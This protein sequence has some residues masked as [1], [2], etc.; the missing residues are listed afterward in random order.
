VV[1]KRSY[2]LSQVRPFVFQLVMQS[3][4]VPTPG[5]VPQFVQAPMVLWQLAFIPP[6]NKA[7][8]LAQLRAI[9]GA[10]QDEELV[11]QVDGMVKEAFDSLQSM[12][13]P[14][15]PTTTP[16]APPVIN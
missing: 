9:V 16:V 13:T 15:P 7:S 8:V 5:P 6:C 11:T 10:E 2:E 3:G 4:V 14:V 1:D 12:G